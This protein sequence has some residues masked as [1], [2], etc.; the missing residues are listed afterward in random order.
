MAATYRPD[1]ETSENGALP[2]DKGK[3][4]DKSVEDLGRNP[5]E[6]PTNHGAKLTKGFTI[7]YDAFLSIIDKVY[8]WYQINYMWWVLNT[9]S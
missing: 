5:N 6:S 7:K 8:S 2:S 1:K 4:A 3:D 9:V